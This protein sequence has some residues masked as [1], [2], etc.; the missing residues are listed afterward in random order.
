M[1]GPA[2]TSAT[3][4]EPE[5]RASGPRPERHRVRN[6]LIA[7]A[8]LLSFAGVIAVLIIAQPFTDAVGS[9]GGG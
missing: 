1:Y 3:V 7:A 2:V 4:T 6:A 8:L 5:D 9:C